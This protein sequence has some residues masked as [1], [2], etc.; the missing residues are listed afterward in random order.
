LGILDRGHR[1]QNFHPQGEQAPASETV[2][3]PQQK[4]SPWLGKYR[5]TF[6]FAAT[7]VLAISAAIMVVNLVIGGLA[8]DNLIRIAEENTARDALHI[9]SMMPMMLGGH[10]MDG[11]SSASAMT[12]GDTMQDTQ[13]PMSPEMASTDAMTDSGTLQDMQQPMSPYMA[14]TDAMT[15][16]GSMQNLQQ[17]MPLTLESLV[18]PEGLPSSYQHLV[19]GLNIVEFN[20][21]DPT[22]MVVW[23]T[24]PRMIGLMKPD[25]PSYQKASAGATSS[26]LIKDH[27]V[28]NSD[29]MNRR[30]DVVE[31]YLPLR[32]TP[33]GP[34]IGVMGIY[35]DVA[36]DVAIQ[37]DDAKA[38]V[39]WTAV[40]TMGGLF[41]VLV[42]FIV[43]ADRS[44]SQ[45]HRTELLLVE[46]QLAERKRAGEELQQA[47]DQALEATRAKSEFLASMSHEIRT[48]MNAIIG[49][50]DLLIETPLT[51][52]QREYVRVFSTAGES[53]L[54]L[55]NDILDLS[56]VE[57]GQLNLEEVDFD[58]GEL[59]ES[60]AQILAVRAH[61]EGLEL[62][63]Q[64]GPNVLTALKGDPARLRQVIT[65][66]VGNAIKFTEQ[67]EVSL[68]VE[69]NPEVNEA[70]ALR[71]RVFD[72]GIGIPQEK[73][74]SIFESF[75]QADSSTT[76]EYGGT[77][78]GL[79]ICRRLVEMM[80][81]RIWVDSEVGLGSTFYFTAKFE[82]QAE[83]EKRAALS[84]EQM[85]GLK[86][87]IVDD[88]ATNRLILQETLTAW[89]A[90]ATVVEDGY[91]CLAEL[92]RAKE[93][94]EPYQ[95]LLLDRRM[96]GM[97]GFE[98]VE[99]IQKNLDTAD[100][101][102]MMLTSDNRSEDIARC[103]ELGVS[104]YLIKPVRRSELLQAI[105]A[106]LGL[107]RTTDEEPSP[108]VKSATPED[109]RALR[110]L[111]VE[112]SQHNRLL[113]QSYLKKTP[114]RI[115]VAEDGE[116]AVGKFRSQEYDLVL[117]DV[118]MPAMDGYTATKL[119]RQWER[120]TGVRS[121]PIIALTAH[122]LSGDAQ[123]SLDAGCTAHLT[124][125][126]RKAALMEA[127][128]EHTRSVTA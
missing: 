72:T 99:Q 27:E 77:G 90:S 58:L 94:D 109:H 3:G 100:M 87:L 30:I 111:L 22:G 41:L 59:V 57:A 91:H 24:D 12:D 9:Q 86:T 85:Q 115:D 98:V 46:E 82:I 121:T 97:D 56:K 11:M 114:Y 51:A 25:T 44:I 38:A 35:R 88:N 52:E 33:S 110:I 78:L 120:E 104:R 32:E 17:P 34:V 125:P 37:V 64:I 28:V 49:M 68:H 69:G 53:L 128:H 14:S 65:N 5:L 123:K 13:Q 63:C 76:R 96:P 43:A 107:M 70:G 20:L 108:M 92:S 105:T 50:A 79:A 102:I 19:E 1:R 54:A 26:Q 116:I 2:V 45:S 89:G 84:W 74:D 61:E 29:G 36:S 55:I 103:Q 42:G 127:I 75:T 126:V 6:L 40:S 67:G 81:G 31:T 117:M 18:G 101:T 62:N 71:F 39:F 113:V 48:P 23:S 10:S 7:A 16:S 95:L 66:L 4:A 8:E 60:T 47:R 80:G 83:P 124:K 119:I 21:I 122:A 112:D 106:T 15:D 73:L 93:K 118:Q